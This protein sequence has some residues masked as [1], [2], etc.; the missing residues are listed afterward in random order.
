MCQRM[1]G[2]SGKTHRTAWQGLLSIAI[3]AIL[4][5]Q[6]FAQPAASRIYDEQ[7][8]V[9]L[10]N[11]DPEARENDVDYGGWLNV[12]FFNYDDAPARIDRRM[13]QYELRAWASMNLKGVHKFYVRGL[14]SFDDWSGQRH[15]E[16]GTEVE[17]AWYQLDLTKLLENGSGKRPPVGVKIKL[18]REFM[19]IGTALVLSTALDMGQIEVTWGDWEFMGFL[20]HT[21]RDSWNIDDSVAVANRQQRW[22]SGA[23]ATYRGW[24]RHRPFVYFMHNDDNTDPSSSVTPVGQKYEYNS[25]YIGIGSTGTLCVPNLRYSVEGVYEFGRTYSAP[26][27]FGAIPG[28]S[29]NIQ[30]WA[31]DAQIEYLFVDCPTKP[32]VGFEYLFASGDSD[33]STSPIGTDGG[34][35]SGTLDHGFGAFGFRDLGIAFSPEISNIHV[36]ALNASF[37]PLEHI[38]LFEKM[39]VGTKLFYYSRAH[40]SGPISDPTTMSEAQSTGFEM[41]FFCNWRMTSDLAWTVRYG[42]FFPGSAY[43]GGDKSPRQFVYGGMVFSF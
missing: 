4:A 13:R 5:G 2:L 20:G 12:A 43:D 36:Y 15:D 42:S 38:E 6:A 24:S 30:A 21:L 40:G 19:T 31:I 16:W 37:L 10:D 18:G 17:R 34:N 14:A 35:R 33:R 32:R 39:E 41:D 28:Q 26:T 23:Q 7:L 1:N 8:R 9:K 29:D 3:L 22:I 27:N 11:L 25:S